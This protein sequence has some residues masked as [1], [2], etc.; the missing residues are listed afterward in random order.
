MV[1]GGAGVGV[2]PGMGV[3]VQ[4]WRRVGVEGVGGR[5]GWRP[6]TL[7]IMPAG[8]RV[9]RP[10]HKTRVGLQCVDSCRMCPFPNSGTTGLCVHAHGQEQ[11]TTAAPHRLACPP[12]SCK[13]PLQPLRAPLTHL[14]TRWRTNSRECA[15]SRSRELRW[16]QSVSLEGAKR[17]I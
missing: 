13:A 12:P 6:T 15:H 11:W 16:R 5:V 2:M 4:F 8:R 9:R 10:N 17:R 1:G 3:G 14:E 7:H